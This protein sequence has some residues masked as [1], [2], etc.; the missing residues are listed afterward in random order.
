MET[1][2]GGGVTTA[3]FLAEPGQ[4]SLGPVSDEW[5]RLPG[6]WGTLPV[7]YRFALVNAVTDAELG[8]LHPLMEPGPQLAHSGSRT[9]KRN[10]TLTLPPAEWARVDPVSNRIRVYMVLRGVEYPLGR[11]LWADASEQEWWTQGPLASMSLID[12]GFI[13]DQPISKGI[14]NVTGGSLGSVIDEMIRTVLDGLPVTYRRQGSPYRTSLSWAVGTTRGQIL[15]ALALAGDYY[16]PWFDNSGVLRFD[17]IQVPSES[18]PIIDYDTDGYVISNA[19]TMT[20]NIFSAPNRVIVVGSSSSASNLP[21]IGIADLPP[22]SPISQEKRGYVV[23][24]V[25]NLDVVS[26]DQAQSMARAILRTISIYR[27]TQL[28]TAPDPRVDGW[29]IVRWN[30]RNWLETDWSLAM[31]PG[32]LMT[33]SLVE[34]YQ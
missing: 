3:R 32:G 15:D 19:V 17:R 24:E 11:Y 33:H 31:G 29:Q 1:V 2:S 21:L 26:R 30:G 20:S 12:E 28:T 16:S 7:S 5:T 22:I 6:G 8:D 9:I 14:T 25:Q 10:L 13:V 34:V 4:L 27:K 23:S 18:V